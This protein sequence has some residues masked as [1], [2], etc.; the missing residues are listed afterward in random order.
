[1]QARKNKHKNK[2][3]LTVAKT[4]DKKKWWLSVLDTVNCEENKM[5]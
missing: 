1:M 2:S 5:H 4:Y 3:Y